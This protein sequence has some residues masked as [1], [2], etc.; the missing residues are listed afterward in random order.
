MICFPEVQR[1]SETF[2]C[3]VDR[4]P[5]DTAAV[6]HYMNM[7]LPHPHHFMNMLSGSRYILFPWESKSHIHCRTF[8]LDYIM[9]MSGVPIVHPGVYI[10]KQHF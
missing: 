10:R 4:L 1:K 6:C 2:S 7:E 8:I 9:L 3:L 5:V